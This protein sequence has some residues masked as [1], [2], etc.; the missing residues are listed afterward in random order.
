MEELLA[1]IEDTTWKMDAYFKRRVVWK[2]TRP[3]HVVEEITKVTNIPGGAAT[4]L[5]MGL[6]SFGGVPRRPLYNT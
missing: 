3:A 4:L 1:G 6:V 5:M 2:R